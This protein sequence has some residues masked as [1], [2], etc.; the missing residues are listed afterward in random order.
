MDWGSKSSL[1]S[2][3]LRGVEMENARCGRRLLVK[4]VRGR[5]DIWKLLRRSCEEAPVG[6][7]L[8]SLR[9]SKAVTD[10]VE[11]IVS[12]HRISLLIWGNWRSFDFSVLQVQESHDFGLIPKCSSG[13]PRLSGNQSET[14]RLKASSEA[15]LYNVFTSPSHSYYLVM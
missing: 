8:T 5:D 2:A 3:S 15:L 9:C 12:C 13:A 7:W 4:L 6:L 1:T 10:L 14:G 11:A